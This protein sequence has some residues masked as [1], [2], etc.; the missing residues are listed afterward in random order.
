VTPPAAKIAAATPVLEERRNSPGLLL[1][2]LGSDAMRKLRQAH[3][4]DGLSPR[5]FHLLALLHDDGPMGQ[6]DLGATVGTDP[7]VL[8]TRLNPLE[9]EGFISRTRDESDR[10]RHVVVLT[11]AG[12]RKL[13]ASAHAQQRAED[14]LFSA[15]DDEQREQLR[16][17]LVAVRDSQ[18]TGEP[19]PRKEDS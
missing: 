4:E 16:A 5:Q 8:I 7:S 6:S 18:P 3:A 11:A 15:L 14:T 12:A 13:H 19:S 17:L 2:L 1:A 9:A 10:R